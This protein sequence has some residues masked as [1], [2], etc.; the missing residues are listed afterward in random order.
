M[1]IYKQI[2]FTNANMLEMMHHDTY[3]ILYPMHIFFKSMHCIINFYADALW[4]G[5]SYHP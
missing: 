5:E 1:I 3:A 4:I 2:G